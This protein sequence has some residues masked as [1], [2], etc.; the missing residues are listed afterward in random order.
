MRDWRPTSGPD[1]A[2]S[3]ATMLR[4][5]RSYFDATGALEVDTPALHRSAASDAQIESLAVSS[6]LVPS[7]LYLHTSPE[8]HMKRL[9]ADGYPDI[10]SICR[11]FRDGE[12]GRRHQPEFTML[13]W[14]RHGMRLSEIVADTCNAIA[15]ALGS[16]MPGGTLD[17]LDYGSAIQSV[18]GVEPANAS[19]DELAVAAG[20]D[21][22]LRRS[23]GSN[24]DDWLDLLVSTRVVSTFPTDQLT[25][26]QHYPASQAALARLC[27]DNS[28]VADRFEIFIGPVELANGYA[29]LTDAAEQRARMQHDQQQRNERGLPL[30]PIDEHLLAALESGLPPCAGVAMGI[31]RL[32][33]VHDNTD[34]IR[35]VITFAFDSAN[36]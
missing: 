7:P 22:D 17:I 4:R 18:C 33:M 29:E 21:A 8:F 5:L 25:V 35:D 14:Y 30:R 6:T 10:Y 11:V 24:R 32:Q 3:R 27:P 15:A 12:A 28:A 9:L 2:R 31:E 16:R 26:L 23:V 13:E 19:I 1:A 20:A 34:D 36:D